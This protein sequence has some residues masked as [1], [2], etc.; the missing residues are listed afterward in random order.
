[1]S[2][3]LRTL[4]V[5]FLAARGA[6]A[7]ERWYTYAIG[8]TPVGHLSEAAS[9]E[10]GALR[11]DSVLVARLNRLGKSFEMRFATVA[12]ETPAGDLQSLGFESL[13]SQQA[14]RLEVRVAGDEVHIAAAGQERTIP[15]G[16]ERLLGPAGVARLTAER[17]RAAG[18]AIEF[19]VFSPELQRVVRVRRAVAA[20]GA[21]GEPPCAAAAGALA[22]DETIEGLPVAHRLWVDAAGAMLADATDGPFGAMTSCR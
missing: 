12:R 18:D 1:M 6:A 11:T 13:L 3:R 14:M 7:E 20:P 4:I 10:D 5:V 17:L 2:R 22:V 9:A 19:A 15:R 16:P 8:G 21:A